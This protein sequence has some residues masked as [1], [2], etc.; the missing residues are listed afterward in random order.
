MVITSA[1]VGYGDYYPTTTASKGLI[2]FSILFSVIMIPPQ[3]NDLLTIISSKSNYKHPYRPKRNENHIILCGHVNNKSKLEQFFKEFFHPDR[4][5]TAGPEYHVVILCPNEPTE[6]IKDLFISSMLDSRVTYVI[7]SA[8]SVEDLKRVRA[9][10][11]SGMFFICNTA[12]SLEGAII[13]D[14]ATVMRMLSVSN[15]NPDVECYVQ[16]IRPED[17]TILKDSDVEFILCLDEFK[18]T[19]QARNSICPGFS[20]FIENIFHTFGAI[21]DEEEEKLP[22]WYSEYLHGARMEMYYVPLDQDFLRAIHFDFDKLCE[23]IYIEFG[24]VVLALCNADQDSIT[25]N[26]NRKDLGKH[27]SF[28]SFFQEFN[29]ALII[30]DDHKQAEDITK[31]LCDTTFVAT[32]L[33]KIEL[34]ED[35]FPVRYFQASTTS[36]IIG[37]DGGDTSS[38]KKRGLKRNRVITPSKSIDGNNLPRGMAAQ[39]SLFNAALQTRTLPNSSIP[40]KLLKHPAD[41]FDSD[42][43]DPEG[44]YIGY[45]HGP[46]G[47]GQTKDEEKIDDFQRS[48]VVFAKNR[49]KDGATSGANGGDDVPVKIIL[50]TPSSSRRTGRNNSILQKINFPLVNTMQ[51]KETSSPKVDISAR[52]VRK[53]MTMPSTMKRKGFDFQ[54]VIQ[55]DSDDESEEEE[56]EEREQRKKGKSRGKQDEEKMRVKTGGGEGEGEGGGGS[57]EE[58]LTKIQ[59]NEEDDE[60]DEKNTGGEEATP[61]ALSTLRARLTKHHAL[62][63]PSQPP[64]SHQEQLLLHA[65]SLWM[66]P[67]SS[68]PSSPSARS[69]TRDPDEEKIELFPT[70]QSL[71]P[72]TSQTNQNRPL[73]VLTSSL[74]PTDP[75]IEKCG[76]GNPPNT[77][78]D[79]PESTPSSRTTSLRSSFLELKNSPTVS[80]LKP[81]SH[82]P[83]RLS[84]LKLQPT[85]A[86]QKKTNDT[87]RTVITP[88]ASR[89]IHPTTDGSPSCSP[90]SGPQLGL[91]SDK[92][93]LKTKRETKINLKKVLYKPGQPEHPSC[94]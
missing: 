62:I 10:I 15:F 34:A 79:S 41:D 6:A 90:I 12:G 49:E 59:E 22:S 87:I 33:Q 73:V 60:D 17:R 16:V 74:D 21:S 26:P 24:I 39:N 83:R 44:N 82:R 54:N 64:K 51:I 76:E 20:T 18:T 78:N 81:L 38:G 23:A 27:R 36:D 8:L 69:S 75:S 46:V 45:R 7:G 66:L 2:I 53:T 48:S 42:E 1:G 40:K 29:V 37:G 52:A 11:A 43:S 80:D 93:V 25:F 84:P 94:F 28:K 58:T 13:E 70:P 68:K 14:A 77:R 35:K 47:E 72:S 86:E 71:S 4:M 63:H 65:A 32:I 55:E 61:S 9:D 50:N 92:S 31:S 85:I 67:S 56:E 5:F 19:L 91:L 89:K 57:R 88:P 3:I 30:A